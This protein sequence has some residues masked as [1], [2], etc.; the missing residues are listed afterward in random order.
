MHN[1]NQTDQ[2][3]DGVGD[4]CDNCPSD[5]NANQEDTDND[6]IGDACDN[7]TDNDGYGKCIHF[8]LLFHHIM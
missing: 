4:V 2:D 6:S 8:V 5:N 7:D 1:P 3:G